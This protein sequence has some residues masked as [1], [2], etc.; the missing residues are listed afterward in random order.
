MRKCK[1]AKAVIVLKL[2]ML[3]K[4]LWSATNA[5]AL[6]I[7][8]FIKRGQYLYKSISFRSSEFSGMDL[9]NCDYYVR[10]LFFELNVLLVLHLL[11]FS[12]L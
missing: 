8:I 10:V 11:Y 2:L 3:E 4:Q 5:T 7:T 9:V 1:E 12:F 6:K